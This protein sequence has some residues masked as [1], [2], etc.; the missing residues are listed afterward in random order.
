LLLHAALVLIA[1]RPNP[2][3]GDATGR[4]RERFPPLQI[5]MA[6][7]P[8]LARR[9]GA[10]EREPIV[11]L[12]PGDNG[13]EIAASLSAPLA[14]L[15]EDAPAE[16]AASPMAATTPASA[17]VEQSVPD[18]RSV[19]I[20]E[21]Q[22][23]MLVQRLID[24]APAL[25]A[26]ARIEHSWQHDGQEYHA[27]LARSSAA[28]STDLE[29]IVVDII[30]SAHDGTSMRTRLTLAKLAFS[31]F[32]QVIDRWDANV[33]L[34]DDEIV[35]RFHSN[36]SFYVAYDATTAPRFL[37]K[38][39]TAAHGF[40][41]GTAGPSRLRDSMFQGGFETRARRIELPS[42]A[43]PFDNAPIDRESYVHTFEDDTHIELRGDA[44]YSWQGRG[45]DVPRTAYYAPDE[46]AYLIAAPGATLHVSGVVNGRVLI[47]SPTRI[48]IEGDVT[49][50]HDPRDDPDADDY[51]GLVSD[52]TVEIAPPY[53]TGRGDLVVE[54]AIF[55]RRRF[56]V[57]NIDYP[58]TARLLI[59]GSLTAG[60]L[61][62]TEPRY[63][64]RI[65]FDPRLDRARPPGFPT[66]NRYE[67][68]QWET[69]WHGVAI[70]T[71]ETA[72]VQ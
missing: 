53:V 54:A 38:V 14:E 34:H 56:E 27:V 6:E 22:R 36:S 61:S 29:S 51:L 68:A 2:E 65:E 9:A 16:P 45:D 57:N 15:A 58:R 72:A 50:A 31:Q 1:L 37:G 44:S 3:L 32:T 18:M 26:A 25:E 33:Q 5:E 12:E 59:Y 10:A 62:A 46:P 69:A 40:R 49:Y 48:M 67:V 71:N 20:A 70:R 17:Q 60:T 19:Q 55:A 7:E 41:V 47:Y 13:D 52:N 39:T 11:T 21:P 30:A 28:G 24:L 64:T 63:A 23:E 35:G 8:E 42:E 66:S 4:L 43:R